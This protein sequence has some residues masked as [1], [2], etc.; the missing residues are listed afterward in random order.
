[1]QTIP[2]AGGVVRDASQRR[3]A[4]VSVGSAAIDLGAT[5]LGYAS[6]GLPGPKGN[7]ETFVWLAEGSH[8]RAVD[9]EAAAGEVEP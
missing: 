6:S 9:L 5:V 4:L 8:A 7:L 1:M 3:R 2:S